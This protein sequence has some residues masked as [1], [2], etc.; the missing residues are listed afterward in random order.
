MRRRQ[1]KLRRLVSDRSSR[2]TAEDAW[3]ILRSGGQSSTAIEIPTKPSGVVATHGPVRIALGRDGEARLLLPL[4][5]M[6]DARLVMGAPALTIE[7]S[8]YNEGG[9]PRRFLDLTCRVKELEAVFAQVAEQILVR[10]E[11][12]GGSVE[13]AR[14]T[15]EEFRNLLTKSA[16]S[17][18]ATPLIAGLVGELLVLKRLLERSPD[19]WKA[20]RGP[21]GARHDFTMSSNA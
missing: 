18:V 21:A 12:G 9:R 5:P 17:D 8:T 2:P 14:S 15:I 19:G 13:A 20:W 3:S 10:I 16:T 11:S 4:D 1:R 7:A 6:E